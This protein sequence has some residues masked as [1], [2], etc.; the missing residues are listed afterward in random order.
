M[1][2]VLEE[3]FTLLKLKIHA[4]CIRRNLH[5]IEVEEQFYLPPAP[6]SMSPYERKLFCQILKGVK[7]PDGYAF[8]IRHKVHVNERKI[9]GI[10]GHESPIILQHLLPLAVRKILPKTVS[11]GVICICNFFKKLSSPVIR[12]SDMESLEADI[13]ETLSLLETIF[14]PSFFDIMVHLMV[15][16]PTQAKIAGP[17]HFRSM[18]PIER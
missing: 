15:H 18:W 11:A 17:V 3:I 10:K 6:Y 12:I 1:L 4:L 13:A 8:D 5:P 7:F 16:L 2:Q 14:L 9:F